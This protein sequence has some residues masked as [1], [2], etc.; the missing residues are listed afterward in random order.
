MIAY[1]DRLPACGVA[2]I[3]IWETFS[4]HRAEL[5][6]LGL[7]RVIRRLQEQRESVFSGYSTPNKSI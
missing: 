3:I 5:V 4:G 2:Y 1:S 6:G 7:K